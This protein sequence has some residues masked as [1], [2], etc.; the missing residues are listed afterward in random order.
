M[1]SLRIF[2]QSFWCGNAGGAGIWLTL[3]LITIIKFGGGELRKEM[4]WMH[5]KISKTGRNYGKIY[6]WK[7]KMSLAKIYIY[8]A[9]CMRA[10]PNSLSARKRELKH[11]FAV[12]FFWHI[13]EKSLGLPEWLKIK[14]G[15]PGKESAMIDCVEGDGSGEL[16]VPKSVY[17]HISKTL[18]DPWTLHELEKSPRSLVECSRWDAD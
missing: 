8:T 17:K 15:N 7:E 3:S 14:G 10:Y 5:W 1:F 4:L 18:S 6:S 12:V 9:F 11:K 16:G 13:T 2:R